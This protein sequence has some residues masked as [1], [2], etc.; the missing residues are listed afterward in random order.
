M[1]V[2]VWYILGCVSG[3]FYVCELEEYP[4]GEFVFFEGLS[5][6]KLLLRIVAELFL[7]LTY[8]QISTQI[9]GLSQL[10]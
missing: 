6:A 9:R 7:V 1:C 2:C 4:E 5:L 8:L 3:Y 10:F